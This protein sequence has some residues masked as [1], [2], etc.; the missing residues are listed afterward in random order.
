MYDPVNRLHLKDLFDF[1]SINYD[2]NWIY[3]ES[4]IH[5]LTESGWKIHISSTP[6]DFLKTLE[7]VS[8]LV[9]QK[10]DTFKFPVNYHAMLALTTGGTKMESQGKMITIYPHDQSLDGLKRYAEELSQALDNKRFPM[11]KW[12]Y[13]F[14]NKNIFLDMVLLNS[15]IRVIA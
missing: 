6:D 1:Y 10:G 13:Q 11:V 12:D 5:P 9:K 14:K 8:T 4:K 7:K 2:K 15:F 3:L